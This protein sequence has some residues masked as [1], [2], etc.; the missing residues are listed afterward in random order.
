MLMEARTKTA[1]PSIKKSF[2]DMFTHGQVLTCEE[3]CAKLMKLLL[4]DTYT[5]GAHIDIYDVWE[6]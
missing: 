1:D 6:Y 4:E 3:S 5:S 2:V